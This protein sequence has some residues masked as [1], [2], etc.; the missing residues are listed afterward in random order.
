[1]FQDKMLT[2]LLG[3]HTLPLLDDGDILFSIPL[4]IMPDDTGGALHERLAQ[5]GPEALI[6]S[7]ELLSSDSAPREEQEHELATYVT[8]LKRSDGKINWS[9]S[10]NHIDRHVRAYDPWPGTFTFF[11]DHSNIKIF[12]PI[13]IVEYE[14]S[15]PGQI[16]DLDSKGILVACGEGALRISE[17]QPSGKRRMLVPAYVAGKELKVGDFL[18]VE[19]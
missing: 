9:R 4:D 19:D 16:I 1:M 15:D 12:P 11:P 10:A 6:H 17:I 7:L 2:W 13:E 8:K 14:G 5:L 3:L 18:G